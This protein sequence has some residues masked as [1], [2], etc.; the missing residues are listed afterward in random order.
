MGWAGTGSPG[1]VP[2]NSPMG[3]WGKVTVRVKSRIGG[4]GWA[5]VGGFKQ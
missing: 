2:Q 1:F 4:R 5:G 3:S